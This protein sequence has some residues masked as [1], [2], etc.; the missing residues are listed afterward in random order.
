[1]SSP[2][3]TFFDPKGTLRDVPSADASKALASG[4]EKAVLFKAP[5]GKQRWVRESQREAAL[6][7]G[8]QLVTL[9]TMQARPG[10]FTVPGIK[11]RALDLVRQGSRYLPD[12]GGAVGGVVGGI[13]GTPLD[14]V[15]GPAGTVVGAVGGAATGGAAGE[16]L[17]QG[18]LHATGMDKQDQPQTW[19]ERAGKVGKQAAYQGGAELLGQGAGKL[20]RPTVARTIN[21]LFA[22]GGL[23]KGEVGEL[24]TVIG[25]LAR[26]EKAAGNKTATIGQFH[27]LL[28]T[29]KRNV[30]N[31]VD[32]AMAQPVLR[33]GKMIPLGS[34]EA[35]VDPIRESIRNLARS[36]PSNFKWNLSRIKEVLSR[37]H[38]YDKPETF[39]NL[40]DRRIVLNNNLRGLYSL[41]KGEQQA[42]LLAHPSL[43]I[44]K[45]E[46]D[47]IRDVIYPEMDR[48]AGKP[49]GTTAKLQARRGALMSLSSAVEENVKKLQAK[50]QEM[51]GSS[52]YERGHIS[53][54]GTTGGRPGLAAHR[55]SAMVHAPNYTAG[56]NRKVASAFGHTGYKGIRS[57]T[58]KGLSTPAG[59]EV[60]TLPVRLLATP[61]APL[62][63]AQEEE[64]QS[65]SVGELRDKASQL[66]PQ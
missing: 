57:K 3:V 41:P 28:N 44:D 46:A 66:N 32:L 55:I 31:E 63:A 11:E 61:D 60:M 58:A 13:V 43:E 39:K 1:M 24:E 53:E 21:K 48:A 59:M 64:E 16:A 47:A 40:T 12:I 37:S 9:P 5:D 23:G 38:G 6:K 65:P 7:A 49:A 54:Y 20:L 22:A 2:T 62:D 30:G 26:T 42:Y 45:A 15:S 17:R 19:G 56:A 51:A 18:A 25:D 35:N 34:A 14:V 27:D 10:V 50:T 4:G 52:W 36:H 29:T 33:N 8:G